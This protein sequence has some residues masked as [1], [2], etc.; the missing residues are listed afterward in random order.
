MSSVQP[1][2]KES[3]LT[4]KEICGKLRGKFSENLISTKNTSQNVV[5]KR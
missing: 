1:A 3:E 2:G 4:I 5:S